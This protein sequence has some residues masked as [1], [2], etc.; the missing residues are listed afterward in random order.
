MRKI[1]LS[2]CLILL[3]TALGLALSDRYQLSAGGLNYRP[4]QYF[5]NGSIYSGP[6]DKNNL[7]TGQGTLEWPNGSIYRG[8]FKDGMMHGEGHYTTPEGYS[9]RGEFNQG[10]A[11]G[12]ATIQ[13][14]DGSSYRGQVKNHM[15]H[16]VGNLTFADGNYYQGEFRNDQIEGTGTWV[17]TGHHTYRGTLRAGRYHGRGEIIFEDGNRYTGQ[18]RDGLY[19]GLGL[20]AT[21]DGVRYE[22]YFENDSFTGEGSATF[23]DGSRHIGEF[24]DWQ[25]N[26]EGIFT[27]DAGN[28]YT[29]HFENG[30]L[31]GSGN[32]I[33]I[34]GDRYSGGFKY[35]KF[36][37]EGELWKDNGDHYQG[38]FRYGSRHGEGQWSAGD[39][40]ATIKNYTGRWRNGR[41][42]KAHGDLTVYPPTLLAEHALYH[43]S[44]L[45]ESTLQGI[46]GGDDKTIELFT[47]GVGAYGAEEVFHKEI[48]FVEKQFTERFNNRKHSVFLANTRRSL[49]SYPL[50]TLSSI[51]QSLQAIASHMNTEQDVLF[52]YITSHGAENKSIAVNQPGLSLEDIEAKDLRRLLDQSG[53]KWRV[54][55]LSAC[56]SG[57]FIDDLKNDNT[58]IITA[59]AADKQ[60]FGCADHNDFTYFGE[61]FFKESLPVSG[62]FVEAFHKAEQLI[63]N[64]EKAENKEHSKPQIRMGSAISQQLEQW[65]TQHQP[66]TSKGT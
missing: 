22:G 20:F 16:G 42:I 47:L 11:S 35:G 3:G 62:T 12:N 14:I 37:G 31:K 41:L 49:D 66:E 52:L 21:T 13:Y 46:A 51:R 25:P 40:E 39:P 63:E 58:L 33:G 19:H 53:I 32:Y 64:W 18:F 50:A 55:V 26:G 38:G 44:S 48:R 1:A 15:R 61:A 17:I 54:I 28:Q 5:A 2:L 27:D 10:K 30:Y 57:G 8:D 59:A 9:Y 45:L 43:Q 7:A 36:S 6:L 56:Y 29:G 4:V 24:V 23:K 65:R 60:S 34:N